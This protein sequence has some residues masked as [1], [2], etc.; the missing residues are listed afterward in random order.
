L[1]YLNLGNTENIELYGGVLGASLC[2]TN[3]GR[4]NS[5]ISVGVFPAGLKEVVFGEMFNRP[6]GQNVLPSDLQKSTFGNDFNQSITV[7][8]LPAGLKS[9]YFG[10]IT[11]TNLF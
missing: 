10:Y 2:I 5:S 11:S 7:D 6:L 4:H 8:V 3:F 1:E 9:L